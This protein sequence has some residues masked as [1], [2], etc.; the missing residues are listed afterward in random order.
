MIIGFVGAIIS[1]ILVS[2][3]YFVLYS[4]ISQ[5]SFDIV[6]LVSYL[7]IAPIIAV[8][9]VFVG[10]MIGIIGSSISMRKYLKV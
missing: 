4:K 7:N 6:K 2:W 10:C 1:F 9:F 5:T 8:I 3:G